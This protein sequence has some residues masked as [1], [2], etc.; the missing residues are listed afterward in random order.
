MSTYHASITSAS[1]SVDLDAVTAKVGENT[2]RAALL[3]CIDGA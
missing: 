1:P 3:I 2:R